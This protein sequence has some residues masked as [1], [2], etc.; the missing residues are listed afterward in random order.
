MLQAHAAMRGFNETRDQLA[1]LGSQ[2]GSEYSVASSEK[3]KIGEMHGPQM[4]TKFTYIA[5]RL[6]RAIC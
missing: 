2:F 1:Q 6:N 4:K 5:S 3:R